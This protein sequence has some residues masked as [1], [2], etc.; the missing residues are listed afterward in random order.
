M[1]RR[2]CPVRDRCLRRVDGDRIEAVHGGRPFPGERMP[3]GSG[4]GGAPTVA[5]PGRARGPSRPTRCHGGQPCPDRQ[6]DGTGR[7][8]T[9]PAVPPGATTWE[10]ATNPLPGGKARCPLSSGQCLEDLPGR[11]RRV[12]DVAE[13]HSRISRSDQATSSEWISSRVSSCF[14]AWTSVAGA[15]RLATRSGRGSAR[16]AQPGEPGGAVE[17]DR[18]GLDHVPEGPPIPHNEGSPPDRRP[19]PQHVARPEVT[20]APGQT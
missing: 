5:R 11:G 4:T 16:T 7:T 6:R 3:E 13:A 1:S 18:P 8:G 12:A 15:R 9:T 2:P 20:V 14:R 17:L 10:R 19:H